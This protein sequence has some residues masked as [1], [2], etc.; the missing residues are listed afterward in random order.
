MKPVSPSAKGVAYLRYLEETVSGDTL[1]KYFTDEEGEKVAEQ[2]L[3]WCSYVGRTVAIRGRYIED[4]A[5]RYIQENNITQMMNIAAGLN[6]FP[7]RHK[8]AAQLKRYA[9][10]DLP[11]MLEFKKAKIVDLKLKR[12]IS[13]PSPLVEYFPIDLSSDRFAAE[14][15][16]IPWSREKPS[17]YVFEG[18]SYYLPK[19]K[20]QEVIDIFADTMVKDLS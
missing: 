9:E 10:L 15:K 18:M 4:V 11:A 14:L 2:W 19:K 8:T 1:A 20:L 12:L 5:A 17:I 6:T 16:K 7:Y 3:K 13:T